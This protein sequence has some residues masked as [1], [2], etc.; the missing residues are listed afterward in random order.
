M[1]QKRILFLKR[2]IIVITQKLANT[3]AWYHFTK[4]KH[5]YNYFMEIEVNFAKRRVI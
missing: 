1:A 3:F 5:H 2:D 4:M